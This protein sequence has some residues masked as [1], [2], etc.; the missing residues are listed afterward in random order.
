MNPR[1]QRQ[2]DLK[3][4]K[5]LQMAADEIEDMALELLENYIEKSEAVVAQHRKNGF[6]VPDNQPMLDKEFHSLVRSIIRD[7]EPDDEISPRLR[8][9]INVAN[10]QLDMAI[11]HYREYWDSE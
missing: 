1:I 5:I 11:Q 10:D 4:E 9:A 7:G 8:L 2:V 6:S 3:S